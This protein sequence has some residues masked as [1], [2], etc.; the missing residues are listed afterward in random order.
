MRDIQTAGDISGLWAAIPMPW[1]EDGR[2][3]VGKLQRNIER[4]VS[5]P[6]DGIYT[7]D[8]DG[9]FYALDFEEFRR[10]IGVF[11]RCFT[12]IHCGVQVGVTWTNT[13]GIIDRIKVCLDHGISAVHICYPYWMPLNQNDVKRFWETL[14]NEVPA[15]RWVHYNTP[16]GH[17]VMN[18]TWYRWLADEYPEQFIGTK[19][20]TQ[21]YL[22][23]SEIIGATPEIAHVVTDFVVVPGMM[24]GA[25]GTYS[26]WVNTLPSWQRRLIDLCK[27]GEWVEATSMQAKFNCWEMKCVDPLVKQGYLHGIVGKAR[28]AASGFLEDTGYTRAPY[29]PIHS[30]GIDNLCNDFKK[31]WSTELA[32]E[33]FER[34]AR[35][36]V[37][38]SIEFKLA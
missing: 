30:E 14:A 34:P 19:L 31:W 22:E 26:F 29:F 24:L 32:N 38:D 17:F 27:A 1:T 36:G 28:G 35:S 8:S 37:N 6:C 11:A 13:Q 10:F 25:R 12:S 20:G 23:L 21:N 18:G 9:E 3:D 16:R 2:L 33:N 7:T 15:A 5:V 4:L